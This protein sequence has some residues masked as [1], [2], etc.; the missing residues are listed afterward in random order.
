MVESI[1]TIILISIIIIIIKINIYKKDKI[2]DENQ[3]KS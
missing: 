2:I 3:F 1:L